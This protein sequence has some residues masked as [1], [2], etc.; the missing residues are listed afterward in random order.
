MRL[1]SFAATGVPLQMDIPAPR[2][3]PWCLLSGNK[4]HTLH[5]E[6][7][8]VH[9]IASLPHF[10]TFACAHLDDR[11]RVAKLATAGHP[12]LLHYQAAAQKITAW[13]TPSLGLGINHEAAFEEI[14]IAIAPGDLLLA[15][16]DGVI[17]ASNNVAEQFDDEQLRGVLIAQ[18][19][20][21]ASEISTAVIQAVKDFSAAE[22]LP[23]DATVVCVRIT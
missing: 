11:S 9:G 21:S 3:W 4:I 14:E 16:T 2:S 23:D 20:T 1:S 6:F 8:K 12:P 19:H 18:K 22:T 13:R 7:E 17:E 15:Y 5:Y 10:V